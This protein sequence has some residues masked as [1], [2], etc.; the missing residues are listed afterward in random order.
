MNHDIN[1]PGVTLG[2]DDGTVNDKKIVCHAGLLIHCR[3]RKNIKFR[4]LF[5]GKFLGEYG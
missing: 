3:L 1:R 2:K 5:R 4:G